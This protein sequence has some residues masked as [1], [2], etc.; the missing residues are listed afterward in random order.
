MT[1]SEIKA[2]LM[3]EISDTEYKITD[4][5]MF[6]IYRLSNELRGYQ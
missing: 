3:L 1:E 4:F 5:N 6:K 2:L